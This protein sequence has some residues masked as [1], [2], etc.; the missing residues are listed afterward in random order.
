LESLR[1]T[2]IYLQPTGGRAV[3]LSDLAPAEQHQTPFL[4]TA[5]PGGKAGIGGAGLVWPHRPDRNVDG[6]LLRCGGRF[7]RKGIG[8]H[9]SS[10]LVFNISPLPLKEGQVPPSPPPLFPK[11]ERRPVRF[12][13]QVGID[14][15]TEGGGSVVFR[16]LV[17]GQERY[18][19]PVV[20]G[21]DA[22]LPV[23]VALGGAGRLELRVDCADRA[24]VLDHAD[25]LDARLENRHA[26]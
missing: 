15:S 1:S 6:G 26:Q 4:P 14:D 12:S 11:G 24:D 2:L 5:S 16:V 9:A 8:V 25:W 17:D 3:Y 20:R 22:P 19:S 7:Y 13:A 18:C 10:R 21:G 23:S